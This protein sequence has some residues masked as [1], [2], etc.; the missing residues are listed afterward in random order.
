MAQQLADTAALAYV[1]ATDVW[2]SEFG[3]DPIRALER[4]RTSLPYI[5]NYGTAW[6]WAATAGLVAMTYYL[7]GRTRES[8]AFIEENSEEMKKAGAPHMRA[9]LEGLLFANLSIQGRTRD[10]LE[11]RA[12]QQKIAKEMVQSGY[13]Q[14]M[15]WGFGMATL[16]DQDDLGR[17]FED[18]S[19]KFLNLTRGFPGRYHEYHSRLWF[20][21]IAY[22]RLEQYLHAT[23]SLARTRHFKTLQ[24]IVRKASSPPVNAGLCPIYGCHLDALK[25]AIARENGRHRRSAKLLA[26]AERQAHQVDSRWGEWVVHRERA[27]LARQGNDEVSMRQ[28]AQKALDLAIREGWRNRVNRIQKEFALDLTRS[29]VAIRETGF[30]NNLIGHRYLDALLEVSL[31]STSSLDLEHQCKCALDA[32]VRVFAAERAFL[33]LVKPESGTLSMQAGRDADGNDLLPLSGFSSTVVGRVHESQQPIVVAG[34]E[35]AEALGSDSAVAH[36]LRSI[37]AAPVVLRD[38]QLG[39]VYVDSRL[40][41]GLFGSEHVAILQAIGNHLGIAVEAARQARVEAER[42][43]Q[44]NEKLERDVEKRTA[45]LRVQAQEALEARQQTELAKQELEH[46]Y[47]SLAEHDRLKSRFFANVSHEL[48]TPLTL[49]LTPLERLLAGEGGASEALRTRLRSMAGNTQRLLRLVNQLLDFSRLESGGTTVSFELR[50]VRALVEPIMQGFSFFARSKGLKLEL[51]GPDDLPEV[52]VDPGKLDKVLCN[53]LSNACKFTE[54]G[55]TVVVR[56]AS[57]QQSLR[58]SV[59]DTG[60]G[61]RD[62]DLPKIFERFRQVD[63]GASRRYEGTGIGLALAKELAE[64]VGGELGA[65]SELGVGSTF[66]VTLPLGKEHVKDPL[67]IRS[68][69]SEDQGLGASLAAAKAL[70]AEVGTIRQTGEGVPADQKKAGMLGIVEGGENGRPLVLVVED[71]ADMRDLVAEICRSDYRVVTAANGQEGLGL[72]REHRP[73]LVVSD[74]MMPAMDGHE[75]LRRIRSDPGTSSIPVMLLTAKTGLELK[76]ESL[77]SGADDYLTKPFESRELLA[78][79]RNLVRLQRQERELRE[80]SA[81]LQQEVVSQAS[82]LERARMLE[83]YLPPEVARTVLEEGKAE[84]QQRQRLTAFRLELQGFDEMVEVVEPEDLPAM[85]NGYLSAMVEVAFKHGATVDKFIRDTVVGFVGAPTTEGLEQDAVRCARMAVAMWERAVEVCDQWGGLLE[86][87]PP[88]PTLVLASGY[89]TVGNFGSSSRM[90]YTAV[91]GPVDE[92]CALLS[93]VGP[94]EVVCSQTTWALI[95]KE[96]AGQPCGEVTM[97]HR[98]RPVKLYRLAGPPPQKEVQLATPP[99][100]VMKAVDTRTTPEP[101][102]VKCMAA[103][104]ERSGDELE[105]GM[106]LAERY[107]VLGRLGEGGMGTVYHARDLKLTA[108]VALKLVRHDLEIDPRRLARLY[109][110]VKLARLVS[111]PNVARIYDLGEWEGH[112]FISME[113]IQG[114]T[115]DEQLKRGGAFPVTEGQRV[116]LQLC[117]GLAAAHAAGIVHRDLKPS[118]I[119]LERGG[120]VV[121]LDFG[122][123][124]WTSTVQAADTE[125]KG[126]AIGTPHYM[127]PEQFEAGDVDHRADIYSLGLVGYE[128]FTDAKLFEADNA[129]AL[130]YKHA[131]EAPPDPQTLRPDLPPR[132]AAVILRCLAKDPR[133]RF[134]SV[135]EI[136]SLLTATRLRTGDSGEASAQA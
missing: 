53:L 110:E 120:R 17:E 23:D 24:T 72:I 28:H 3:G 62:E 75:L 30:P 43:Q 103:A 36:E 46:A 106:V 13:V 7:Q 39:V 44:Q 88:I 99:P 40:V 135:R 77:E 60:I 95:Q 25:A 65:E 20:L 35:E 90:E 130:A 105:K 96:I 101:S 93:S 70:T 57:D 89:S 10:A 131:Y 134:G 6:D 104:G 80:L 12:E 121:I 76:L 11:H 4:S 50:D 119:M 74:V 92:T 61:I 132:I 1:E 47:D 16:L 109:R 48:R 49:I 19:Q 37:M 14:H 15:Y 136:M 133:E 51:R 38:R 102:A 29:P 73:A 68:K 94:G 41:K 129:V 83:R 33:F 26:S 34:T 117:S 127:A 63:G 85:L 128:M 125:T 112:E 107:E 115:L 67:L 123:A 27:R 45:E 54:P 66:T 59:K 82:A 122:I 97:R 5:K 86:G 64:L 58:I 108:D 22:G 21:M 79:A 111:H 42:L 98:S 2:S 31:A 71:N 126:G 114:Q 81:R 52:Y 87:Q 32:L 91:G 8:I 9:V 78:R 55:G 84:G 18:Y 124:R 69:A 100:A 116:L 113:Y 118:N 56:L